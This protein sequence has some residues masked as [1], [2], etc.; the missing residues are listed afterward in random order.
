MCL[1]LSLCRVSLSPCTSHKL[2]KTFR[3]GKKALKGI[4]LNMH[5]GIALGWLCDRLR[6][7]TKL[8]QTGSLSRGFA[9]GVAETVSLPFFP[10]SSVFFLFLCFFL[11]FF[12]LSSVFPF[13]FQ[14]KN[15]HRSRDPYCETPFFSWGWDLSGHCHWGQYDYIPSSWFWWMIIGNDY[16][17]LY[18]IEFRGSGSASLSNFCREKNGGSLNHY[19]F[20]RRL[21]RAFASAP[22]CRCPCLDVA[23]SV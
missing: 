17:K 5:E 9:K 8:L 7:W 6:A 10:F 13:H 3:A 22:W 20:S 14:N 1:P 21:K 18:S 11:A 23:F 15:W 2:T 12:P 19:N 4:T 16:S